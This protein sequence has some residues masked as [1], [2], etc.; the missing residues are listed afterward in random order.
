VA[1]VCKVCGGSFG[2]STVHI[3]ADC[4]MATSAMPR[5]CGGPIKFVQTVESSHEFMRATQLQEGRIGIK[6]RPRNGTIR[7]LFFFCFYEITDLPGRSEPY[8][9][10]VIPAPPAH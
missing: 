4:E 9:C 3:Y 5:C 2:I 8:R 10:F 6:A 1:R 7:L